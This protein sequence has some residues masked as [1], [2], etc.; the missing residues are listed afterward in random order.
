MDDVVVYDTP[1]DVGQVQALF[2]NVDPTALPAPGT[3]SAPKLPGQAGAAGTWGVREILGYSLGG[4]SYTTLVSA[5]RIIRGATSGTVRNY[6][7]PV[8]NFIDPG[9][10]NSY[11]FGNDIAF[12]TNTAAD[13]NNLL[14]VGKGAVRIAEEDDYTF[15]FR[16]DDGGRL[17]VL[18]KQFIN[19]TRVS[20]SNN[21]DPAH[22]GDGI[23]FINSAGDSHTFGVVHLTPGDYNLE[24][25]Y[26]EN[27]GSASIEVF[28][29]R[30]DK[31]EFDSDFKLVGD[32][33]NGGLP[34]VPDPDN[35]TLNANGGPSVFVHNGTPA[36][37]SLAWASATTPTSMVIDQGIGTVS[38]NGSQS[39]AT[40]PQT[41]V[42]T[43]TATFG[44]TTVIR[45]VTVLST[46]LRR[47]HLQRTE[48]GCRGTTRGA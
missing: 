33:A 5:D 19:S 26:W 3:Y 24:L 30:G 2:N 40:P 14:V 17:R 45:K 8:I 20:T 21:I 43:L 25:V 22:H 16:G 42:Y 47:S 12:N 4:H 38:Q 36:T 9:F 6:Q 35:V 10:G 13:D 27:T 48:A 39:I 23:Y 11:N 44:T 15:G 18:G 37:F 29:A 41:T 32:T 28:A 7:S 31:T 34:L 46:H 1:L